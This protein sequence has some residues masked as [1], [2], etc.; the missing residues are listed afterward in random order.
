MMYGDQQI[1][2]TNT[3]VSVILTVLTF[4]RGIMPLELA[5]LAGVAPRSARI[6]L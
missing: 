4:A 5:R 1:I 6:M 3:M 2:K